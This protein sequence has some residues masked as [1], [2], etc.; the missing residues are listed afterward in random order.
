[1]EERLQ[2]IL[3]RHGVASRRQAEAMIEQ[4]LKLAEAR[5]GTVADPLLKV[6]A[7]YWDRLMAGVWDLEPEA[8]ATFI[9]DH[10]ECYK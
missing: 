9:C 2:K 10:Y 8:L 6:S 7:D 5:G 3:S 4:C 1:M